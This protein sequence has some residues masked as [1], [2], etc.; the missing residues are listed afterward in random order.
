MTAFLTANSKYKL[1]A[2][3][4]NV[5]APKRKPK[6][7]LGTA[8]LKILSILGKTMT[9]NGIVSHLLTNQ[10]VT[11]RSS[12]EKAIE[13]LKKKGLIQEHQKQIKVTEAGES[14]QNA[15]ILTGVIKSG[16][17]T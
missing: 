4:G 1:L 3:E 14:L 12:G 8:E 9:I 17:H 10:I 13:S 16:V 15:L 11:S 6:F 5:S 7:V 2:L